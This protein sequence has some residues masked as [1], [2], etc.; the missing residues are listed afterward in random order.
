MEDIIE[1]KDSDV[2]KLNKEKDILKNK[3]QKYQELSEKLL[4]QL[5]DRDKNQNNN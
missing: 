4:L 1:G 3:N 5:E 2:S